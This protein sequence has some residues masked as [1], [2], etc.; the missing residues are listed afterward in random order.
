MK[1]EVKSLKKTI[2]NSVDR[3]DLWHIRQII[4]SLCYLMQYLTEDYFD[5]FDSNDKADSYSILYEFNRFRAF[6][7]VIF[8]GIRTVD[9]ELDALKITM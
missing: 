9:K 7:N 3:D 8:D 6:T 1:K 5:K 2:E 4:D